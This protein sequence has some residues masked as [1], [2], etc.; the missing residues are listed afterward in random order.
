MYKLLDRVDKMIPLSILLKWY[1]NKEIILI[2]ETK[3]ST[4]IIFVV[5]TKGYNAKIYL[6]D[7]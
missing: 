6:Y 1:L 4:Q 5:G 2:E 7:K 3:E